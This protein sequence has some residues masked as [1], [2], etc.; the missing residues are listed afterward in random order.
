MGA[1][2]VFVCFVFGHVCLVSVLILK[3]LVTSFD[4]GCNCFGFILQV[5]IILLVFVWYLYLDVLVLIA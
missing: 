1:S 5:D 2:I 4:L 3:L